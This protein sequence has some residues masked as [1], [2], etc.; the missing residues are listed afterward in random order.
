MSNKAVADLQF[1]I[2]NNKQHFLKEFALVAEGSLIPI[3]FVFKAPYS[4]EELNED[5]K[6]QNKYNKNAINGLDWDDGFLEYSEIKNI[7]NNYLTSYDVIYVK[8]CKKKEFLDKFISRSGKVINL[9][10]K[11]PSLQKLRN[12]TTI[13]PQH[14]ENHLRCAVKNCMNLYIYLIKEKNWF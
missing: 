12:F 4:F 6:Q 11:I 3:L 5:A 7:L 14:K 2:G 8:G 10:N 13:C 1:V 9:D